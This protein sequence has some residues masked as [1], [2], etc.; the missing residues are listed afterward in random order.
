MT[1]GLGSVW[2]RSSV[3]K[4]PCD[5][6]TEAEILQLQRVEKDA[7]WAQRLLVDLGFTVEAT[8]SEDNTAAISLI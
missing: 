1:L 5:S 8:T 7:I 2:H 3:I 4:A 6:S